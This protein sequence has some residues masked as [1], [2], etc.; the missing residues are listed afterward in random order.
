LKVAVTIPEPAPSIEGAP[1]T[2]E[3]AG[4]AAAPSSSATPRP[5]KRLAPPSPGTADILRGDENRL[6]IVGNVAEEEARYEAG[7]WRAV[8]HELL[9]LDDFWNRVGA[10]RIHVVIH[11]D[12][13]TGDA[14]LIRAPESLPL[15]LRHEIEIAVAR[16]SGV[17]SC[18][19]EV[20]RRFGHEFDFSFEY[21][22]NESAAAR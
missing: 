7:V 19:D 20:Q 14:G 5:R 15:P 1:T 18:P 13:R 3:A 16:S 11:V 12:S 9:R 21:V 17:V 22:R 10:E 2:P 6:A 4:D 8:L